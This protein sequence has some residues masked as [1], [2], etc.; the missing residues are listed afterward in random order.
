MDLRHLRAFA[1]VADSR[2]FSNAARQLKVAQPPLSRQIQQLERELGVRLFVRSAFG[3]E[4]TREGEFLLEKARVVLAASA[5]LLE[6]AHRAE[7]GA[8]NTVRVGLACGL[9]NVIN[10]IRE[11]VATHRPTVLL[12][13]ADLSSSQQYEALRRRTIDVGLLRHTHNDRIIQSEPL[14]PE[15]FVVLLS[16]GHPLA[17][18]RSI[19]LKEIA[20]DPLL[21]HEKSRAPMAYDKI[22]SLYSVAGVVPEIVTHAVIPG[23]QAA[24]LA[25]ASGRGVC[26]ALESVRSR[27]YAQ[28]DGIAVVPLD[29]PNATLDVQVVWRNSESSSAVLQFVQ[30]VRDVFPAATRAGPLYSRGARRARAKRPARSLATDVNIGGLYKS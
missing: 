26:L 8:A 7:T 16:S 19:R 21:I 2:S 29:E 13:A 23:G 1:A 20:N 4:L 30:S 25:V 12:E 28:A 9:W 5:D 18:R 11:H 24:M 17:K 22:L 3:V 15:G 10:A 27:S 14:F 6:A